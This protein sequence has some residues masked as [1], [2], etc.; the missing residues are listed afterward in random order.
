MAFLQLSC[1]LHPTDTSM[2]Y[3]TCSSPRLFI[4]KDDKDLQEP[5]VTYQL[6][7]HR[8]HPKK[9]RLQ[10]LQRQHVSEAPSSPAAT[11]VHHE[12]T[13]WSDH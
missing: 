3:S 13:L 8:P 4:D 2:W 1:L 6:L 12:V 11:G 5:L 7:S 10:S 9:C